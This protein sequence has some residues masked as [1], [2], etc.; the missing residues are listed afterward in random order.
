MEWKGSGW[1][2]HRRNARCHA[3]SDGRLFLQVGD[4]LMKG[5]TGVGC[6]GGRGESCVEKGWASAVE[7]FLQ[8]KI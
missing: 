8:T 7:L 1:A 2:Q 4:R 6:R 3:E 5:I